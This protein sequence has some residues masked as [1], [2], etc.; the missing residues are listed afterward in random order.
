MLHRGQR[1]APSRRLYSTKPNSNY[2]NPLGFALLAVAAFGAFAYVSNARHSD[3]EK[4]LR[5]KR[6]PH[7][8]PLIPPRT[9][10][11]Q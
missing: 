8:N 11:P 10:D 3:P 2:P 6:I 1:F 4:H 5:E 7:A 9:Q